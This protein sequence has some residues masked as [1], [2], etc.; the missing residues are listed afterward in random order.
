MVSPK[1]KPTFR[2]R[3]WHFAKSS[4]YQNLS[5]LILLTKLPK[6]VPI[7]IGMLKNRI[8]SSNQIA[9]EHLENQGSG[10]G[11]LKILQSRTSWFRSL[12]PCRNLWMSSE[13]NDSV[14]LIEMV[15][16]LQNCSKNENEIIDPV[17]FWYVSNDQWTMCPWTACLGASMGNVGRYNKDF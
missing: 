6:N 7:D 5:D 8:L 13:S 11:F 17:S 3:P 9:V 12:D 16:L 4:F 1:S 15:M 10:P 2:Q 14:G